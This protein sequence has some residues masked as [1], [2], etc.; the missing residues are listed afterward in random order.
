[1]RISVRSLTGDAVELDLEP[2]STMAQLKTAIEAAMQVPV[3]S[4]RLIYAGAQLEDVACEAWRS[5]RG[6]LSSAL[7]Y[8]AV[9]DG[10]P[11]TLEHH[12]LQKGS[13]INLVQKATVFAPHGSS[14]LQASPVG[15]GEALPPRMPAGPEV[16]SLH[17][18]GAAGTVPDH[19]K[20]AALLEALPDLE[21]LRLLRPLLLRRP[22][23]RAALLAD[24]QLLPASAAGPGPTPAG[25]VTAA[26]R[27]RIGA[28]ISVWSNSKQRW[29]PGEV[30]NVAEVTMGNIPQGSVEVAFQMGRKWIAPADVPRMLGPSGGP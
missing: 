18:T 14:Q 4:Q 10:T 24:E 21:A 6:D 2:T 23:L 3:D 25:D 15:S 9:P 5:R 1:M 8:S 13:V 30:V 7:G 28:S 27:Y 17:P 29:Y 26:P 12:G 11:L 22:A 16:G 20:L 19:T